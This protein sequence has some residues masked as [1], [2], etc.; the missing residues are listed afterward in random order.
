MV[1]TTVASPL[2]AFLT[3]SDIHY[4]QE[5]KSDEAQDIGDDFLTIA[6][7]K[8]KQLTKKVDFIL[9][10]GDLP[11]HSLF[12][13]PKKDEYVKTVFHKLFEAD[14]DLKPMF[15]ITGNN[16]SPLG[17]YQ[18]F[19][20]NGKSPLSFATEWTGA[21]VHCEGL[22]IDSTHMN[23]AGYYSSYVIP[24]NKDIVL[25]ALNTNQLVK[26]PFLLPQYPTQEQ[27]ALTQLKWFEQQL[28]NHHAK[29]LLIA[30]HIPPGYSYTGSLFWHEKYLETFLS[31]L[32]NY[33]K[34]YDQLSLLT[35]HTH[36]DEIRKIDLKDNAFV[37][38]YS[39]P[40]ISWNHHN[41]PGIKLFIMNKQMAIIN[42]ITY[43]TNKL[44]HWG[45]QQYQAIGSLGAI[46]PKCIDKS[47]AGCLD[48]L[49]QK[50]ACNYLEQDLFYG[51]KSDRVFKNV[52]N[53]TYKVN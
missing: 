12:H 20:S 32:Q 41:N 3:V 42:A 22:M 28:K 36:M 52:C 8:L 17:N 27:D 51:V 38:S 45:N 31:L 33:H 25:I 35:A 50:E 48:T 53:K 44:T 49:S 39:S 11:T 46:F 13:N 26:T 2:P 1:Q 5:N 14:P 23:K 24:G 29:Q 6:F 34:S 7:N 47:L 4:G 9:V 37:Y 15:Y 10:L 18:A 16:D 21:C 43:Y 30:M 40:S 19:E